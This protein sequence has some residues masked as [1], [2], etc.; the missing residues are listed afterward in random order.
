MTDMSKHTNS[1]H[2][3]D[4]PLLS[5][6]RAGSELTLP[7]GSMTPDKPGIK[8]QYSELPS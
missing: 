3:S 7:V 2:T 1:W 8:K 6:S 5:A 4:V